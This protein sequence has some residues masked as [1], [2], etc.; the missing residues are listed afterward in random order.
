MRATCHAFRGNALPNNT[1]KNPTAPLEWLLRLNA[2]LLDVEEHI[3]LLY[4]HDPN[5]YRDKVLQ[6]AY[7]LRMNGRHLLT[8]WKTSQLVG[9]DDTLL[10]RGTKVEE[11]QIA[12]E[13]KVKR[14]RD[15]LAVDNMLDDF[16]RTESGD[17]LHMEVCPRCK[18]DTLTQ[19]GIQSRGLDEGQDV[20]IM[21][22]NRHCG[23]R[24]R[25]R[26]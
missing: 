7:N 1:T 17:A 26:S 12:H 14:L 8:A 19:Q 21:C 24:R 10:S 22:Q 6:L 16:K 13:Q 15:M 18:Q 25:D 4:C 20:W 11:Q 23:F 3:Y 2:N 5:A 9:L